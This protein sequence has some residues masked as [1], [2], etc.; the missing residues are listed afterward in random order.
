VRR[1]GLGARGQGQLGAPAIDHCRQ[2]ETGWA[3]VSGPA[4]WGHSQ[5]SY[6]I[7]LIIGEIVIIAD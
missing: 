2:A 1:S 3:I 7:W 4:D 5:L 6:Y